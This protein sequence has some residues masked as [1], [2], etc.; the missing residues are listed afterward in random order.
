M[1]DNFFCV[2]IFWDKNFE[3]LAKW[4]EVNIW[5]KYEMNGYKF[6]NMDL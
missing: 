1:K 6:F 2:Q 3:V 5:G 4:V